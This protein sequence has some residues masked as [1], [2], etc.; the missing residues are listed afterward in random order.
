MEDAE[1]VLSLETQLA[2]SFRAPSQLRDVELSFN[3]YNRSELE[4]QMPRLNWNGLLSLLTIDSPTII[5]E[6][7]DYYLLLDKLLVTESLQVWKNKVR[8]TI[9][10]KMAQYLSGDF[11]RTYFELFDQL[12]NGQKQQKPRWLTIVKFIDKYIGEPL[13]RLFVDR[14]FP[15]ASKGLINVLVENILDAYHHRLSQ[16]TWLQ[17]Q[18]KAQALKKLKSVT[19]KVGYPS[20]WTSYEEIEID[21]KS[22]FQSIRNIFHYGYMKKMRDLRSSVVNRQEW[23]VP[24]QVVNAFYV[25][26]MTKRFILSKASSL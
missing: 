26:R 7:P 23:P 5:I 21:E 15:S 8:F 9:L 22:Y 16:L 3:L 20:K 14:H 19:A 13:G 24:P 25:S 10:N 17:P 2:V 12:I 4:D 18:T 11:A 6:H 1:D